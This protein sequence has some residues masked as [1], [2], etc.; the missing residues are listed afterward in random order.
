MI[1]AAIAAVGPGTPSG[2]TEVPAASASVKQDGG[3]YFDAA[4]NPTYHVGPDGTVD[5]YTYSGYRRYNSECIV[6]HGPDGDGSSFAP[7]LANSL[8]TMNYTDF[9]GTVAAGRVNVTSSQDNVMPTFGTNKNVM[10]YI[11]D[12]YVYLRARSDG[13]VLEGR[14]AKY[15]LKSGKAKTDEDQCMGP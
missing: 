14:P 4:G 7:A 15:E 13:V 2:A 3:K 9:L 12:I 5:W 8:K 1:C 6:C 11:D 10:C